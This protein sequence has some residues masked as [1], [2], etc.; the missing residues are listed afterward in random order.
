MVY[1]EQR[2]QYYNRAEIY[3]GTCPTCDAVLFDPTFV[4]EIHQTYPR[5]G[6]DD[7]DEHPAVLIQTDESFHTHLL[8]FIKIE[9]KYHKMY[10]KLQK[11]VTAMM[12]EFRKSVDMSVEFIKAQ[13]KFYMSQVTNNDLYKT[14]IKYR[15]HFK[16]KYAFMKRSYGSLRKLYELNRVQ[17][18]KGLPRIP[19]RFRANR[20]HY[21]YR[22]SRDMLW[23]FRRFRI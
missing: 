6:M 13:K 8:E 22:S 12:K 14:F 9:Q 5:G 19:L 16:K 10:S 2:E 3:D 20:F 11:H 4:D 23:R 18:I 17:G 15:C 21:Y 7:L 1:L